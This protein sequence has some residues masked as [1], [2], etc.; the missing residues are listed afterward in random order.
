MSTETIKRLAKKY[1]PQVV[2][3]RHYFHRN[4]EEAFQEVKTSSQI[5]QTLTEM[6]LEVQTGIARTGV[7]ALIRGAMPGKT[8]LLRADMDALRIQEAAAVE[9]RSQTEGMM[10]ACGHDG[11]IAGLLGAAMILNELKN[12]ISG[13]IKLVFQ[14]A[15]EEQGGALPMIEEGVLENPSVDAAFA[16]HLWGTVQ[17]GNVEV[18][19]GALMAAPDSFDITI[20]GRGGHAAI[21][22]QTIDPV[23]MATH[24]IN[25]IQTVISRRKDPL[26]PAVISFTMIHGGDSYNVI[27]NEVKLGGTIR[28]F[29]PEIRNWIPQTMESI[30]ES[31]TESFGGSYSFNVTRNYPPLINDGAMTS[32]VEHSAAKIVGS[33]NVH[34]RA[35][36]TMGGEDF[37]YFAQAVPSSF[38]FVGIAPDKKEPVI[39]H[40]PKFQWKDRNLM[41]SMQIM[42]QIAVD[43]LNQQS[44]QTQ[45]TQG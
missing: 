1:Y 26:V 44:P 27:P 39:H 17:E 11:H 40:H 42:A 8:V 7:V 20:T 45:H 18:R 34:R 21:P 23:I 37:A 16:C 41:V 33:G 36:P 22:N 4:P 3:L 9:Y 35:L 24:V 2:D 14:P 5:A 30:I 28:T 19:E 6:G 43:Y 31:V 32:L 38:Y 12:E 13:N 29:E 10:H 25:Q 15:E